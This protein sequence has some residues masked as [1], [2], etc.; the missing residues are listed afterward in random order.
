MDYPDGAPAGNPG[1][2]TRDPIS[3]VRGIELTLS[4]SSRS[5]MTR[6]SFP[7][8]PLPREALADGD[9]RNVFDRRDAPAAGAD[10]ALLALRFRSRGWG[11]GRSASGLR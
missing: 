2:T 7:S 5:C 6:G 1:I 4:I 3:R 11:A 8:A 9:R 10:E